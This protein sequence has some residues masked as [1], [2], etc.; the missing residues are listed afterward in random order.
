MPAASQFYAPGATRLYGSTGTSG[1]FEF[2]GLTRR[3]VR[4]DLVGVYT[5]VE[6][7]F[8][9]GVA[10]DVQQVGG[11]GIMS[12]ELAYYQEPILQKYQKLAVLAANVAGAFAAPILTGQGIGTL[13]ASEGVSIQFCLVCP[14]AAKGVNSQTSAMVVGYTFGTCWLDGTWSVELGVPVKYPRCVIRSI[15]TWSPLA[16]SGVLYTNTLPGSLPSPT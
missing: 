3:A 2:L 1:A 16:G 6:A 13:M 7:D 14:A 9:G 15:P 10:A 4:L 5:D 11:Q 12:F 8:A